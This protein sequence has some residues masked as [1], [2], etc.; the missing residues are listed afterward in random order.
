[1]ATR[2]GAPSSEWRATDSSVDLLDA[3]EFFRRG[4]QVSAA[5]TA[6]LPFELELFE[7]TSECADHEWLEKLARR[8]AT[9]TRWVSVAMVTLGLGCSV[10]FIVNALGR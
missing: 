6:A 9:L 7:D 1:M 10:V 3:E 8:R 4:E 5:E 2:L